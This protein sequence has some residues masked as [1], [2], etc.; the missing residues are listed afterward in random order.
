MVSTSLNDLEASAAVRQVWHNVLDRNV[1]TKPSTPSACCNPLAC[2][3]CFCWAET[4]SGAAEAPVAAAAVLPVC[5]VGR[6][7]SGA[8]SGMT[9]WT[10][11]MNS[12]CGIIPDSTGGRGRGA[13]TSCRRE[14]DDRCKGIDAC[15]RQLG[16]MQVVQVMHGHDGPSVEVRGR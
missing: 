2:C 7:G 15:M 9:G 1:T 6:E 10:P 11:L 13:S 16:T 3:C 8:F 4:G 12:Q 5:A 14:W